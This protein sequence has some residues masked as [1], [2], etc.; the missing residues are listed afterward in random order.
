M[1]ESQIPK[2]AHSCRGD[3]DFN[4][5]RSAPPELIT[6]AGELFSGELAK[7]VQEMILHDMQTTLI[8]TG[9]ERSDRS[10]ATLY[11]ADRFYKKL[12]AGRFKGT[13]SI[14]WNGYDPK[15]ETPMFIYE[16]GKFASRHS[17]GAS[18]CSWHD[19]HRRRKHPKSTSLCGIVYA[20]GLRSGIHH[21]RLDVRCPQ[22]W[23]GA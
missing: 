14:I 18:D 12:G 3:W 17:F 1:R 19:G 22:M 13:P 16:G 4:G 21:P 5:E 2:P 8:E 11:L 9:A 6:K 23:R 10:F 7:Q 15:T 20:L